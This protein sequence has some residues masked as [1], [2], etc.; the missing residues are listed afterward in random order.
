MNNDAIIFDHAT[1]VSQSRLSDAMT[2][3][4]SEFCW[5]WIA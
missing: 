2:L 1:A 5:P 3:P 4:R